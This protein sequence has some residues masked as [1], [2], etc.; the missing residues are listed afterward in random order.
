MGQH[1]FWT[2]KEERVLKTSKLLRKYSTTKFKTD[3]RDNYFE[4]WFCDE[5]AV[6]EIRIKIHKETRLMGII[7]VYY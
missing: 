7:L 6:E 2:K 5:S 4:M 1:S 3:K